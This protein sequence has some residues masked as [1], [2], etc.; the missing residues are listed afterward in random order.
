MKKIL[1]YTLL[2]LGYHA[3]AQLTVT[4]AGG[5]YTGL[6]QTNLVGNGVS[7]SN[8]TYTGNA[9]QVGSFTAGGN[10]NLGLSQGIIMA[11]GNIANVPGAASVNMSNNLNGA[12]VPEL[13]TIIGTTTRDG[14]VLSFDI[15]PQSNT[16]TF[17]YVF[18]SEEYPE[19]PN[20]NSQYYDAF[21]FFI[22]GPGFGTPTNIA[23]LPTL[24]PVSIQTVNPSTNSLYYI[25][26]SANTVN[27]FDGTTTVLTATATVVPCQ[28][29]NLRLMIADAVNGFKD[30]GVFI[31]AGS[32][33]S[34]T[35]TVTSPQALPNAGIVEGCTP[36][37]ITVSL[38]QVTQQPVTL[39]YTTGGNALN[40]PDYTPVSGTITIPAG[41][42]SA[43]F[44]LIPLID[45]L[46]ETLPDTFKMIFSVGCV[47]DTLAILINDA[48]PIQLPAFNP[49]T[50]CTAT[51]LTLT[52]SPTGGVAPLSYAW[53]LNG[54]NI[55]NNASVTVTP[56]PTGTTTYFVVVTDACGNTAV[57]TAIVIISGNVTA[58]FSNTG[59]VC[60]QTPVGIAYTGNADT[61]SAQFT[62][63]FGG[64]TATNILGETYSVIYPAA[65]S[66]TVSLTVT[67][68][69]CPPVST[70]QTI[71][72]SNTGLPVSFLSP[73]AQ[74]LQNNSFNFTAQSQGSPQ[75]QTG[76]NFG[77]NATPTTATGIAANNIVF[78]TTGPQLVTLTIDD[79]GCISTFTDTVFVTPP[80]TAQFLVPTPEC[81]Q[82]NTFNFSATNP[83]NQATY[84][85]QMPSGNPSTANEPNVVGVTYTAVGQYLVTLIVTENGCSDTITQ[86]VEVIPSP[87]PDFS[88]T[89]LEGCA[90]L[91]VDFTVNNP[92]IGA[93]YL[94]DFGNTE[95]STIENP[96]YIYT[97]EGSYNVSLTITLPGGGCSG[98]TTLSNYI[99]VA[100][101]P[102]AGFV[103]T[104]PITDEFNT[105]IDITS[106]AQ[107]A[108]N[109]SYQLNGS[110]PFST[111]CNT[112][113]L[114]PDTGIFTITQ[115]VTNAQGCSDTALQN[116]V[117]KPA[118]ALYI[119][120]AF[121]PNA[122]AVNDMFL[123]LGTGIETYSLEIFNRWGE[124]IFKSDNLYIGW[125]GTV[126]G[127]DAPSGT[128]VYRIFYD[129][130]F[131]KAQTARGKLV[132][133][134]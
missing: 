13:A 47:T 104:P 125:D 82:G 97:S 33:T 128:Y 64:G 45:N 51:P 86:S 67:S 117:V 78:S 20:P 6:V 73:A 18:A 81:L 91:L 100:G 76:W 92:I 127:T 115:I 110:T 87:V 7:I 32:L 53:S 111:D 105:L 15:I 10:A 130:P 21:A 71:V 36:A 93:T 62:W 56:N 23:L 59:P 89:P 34:P 134:R 19:N 106:T 46:T 16:L 8:V 1:L 83:N 40:G 5:N 90:P 11:T 124:L 58:T 2:L 3:F 43:S 113:I 94:W 38:P 85:W 39:D 65:G 133:I 35:F 9:N 98:T 54:S 75:A 112:S 68:P 37:T 27:K 132:L 114:L 121:T 123:P 29:Y 84:T 60:G 120:N 48:T 77:A 119:P 126:N 79:N 63:N 42:S 44:N 109:C 122:S 22:S 72:V 129:N 49:I 25:D 80:P 99:N 107:G 61:T 102:V 74:C 24:Q 118:F 95:T 88:A 108:T 96:S 69:G 131:N 41:Q 52:A 50:Q 26:N 101:Q 70:S 103:A 57:E 30:S 31:E 55:G 116:V 17:R 12:G 28:T 66:Y 14:A 4:P